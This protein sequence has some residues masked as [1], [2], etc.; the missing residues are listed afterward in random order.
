MTR[1][2]TKTI[3]ILLLALGSLARA[4]TGGTTAR[5]QIRPACR[6][7]ALTPT[8]R[9]ESLALRA[10]LMAAIADAKELADGF[11]LKLDAR[12]PFSALARFIELE[13]RCCPF[14]RFE[15][16]VAPHGG[17]LWLRLTGADGVKEL[18][19]RSVVP[20]RSAE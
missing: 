3:A 2:M 16:D 6:L 20:Q 13:R 17:P 9:K 5:N 14:F 1:K 18:L 15:L 8:E 4:G 10:A 11:A 7:D 19:R 12:L